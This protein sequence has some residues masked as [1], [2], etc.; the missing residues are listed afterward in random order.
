MFYFK[1]IREQPPQPPEPVGT[2]LITIS[3]KEVV[4]PRQGILFLIYPKLD[5]KNNEENQ[6]NI[7]YNIF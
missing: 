3:G 4:P 6:I 1:V 2:K 5:L 7:I